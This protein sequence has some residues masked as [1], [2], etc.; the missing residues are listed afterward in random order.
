MSCNPCNIN[1]WWLA[2]GVTSA[3]W[4]WKH[5]H[6]DVVVTRSVA[7]DHACWRWVGCH[8]LLDEKCWCYRILMGFCLGRIFI[9]GLGYVLQFGRP[10]LLVASAGREEEV[11]A[12]AGWLKKTMM[13]PDLLDLRGA[14]ES[15]AGLKRDEATCWKGMLAAAGGRSCSPL[16]V[17]HYCPSD[18]AV[19]G[20]D[21]FRRHWVAN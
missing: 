11:D 16:P 20:G 2:R 15:T 12:A 9:L 6:V 18:L 7:I 3:R 13:P 8:R 1:C 4:I 19:D 14:V 21:G 5:Y 17:A 10:W